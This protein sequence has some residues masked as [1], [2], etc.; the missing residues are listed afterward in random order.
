MIRFDDVTMNF[1]QVPSPR[2][3]VS[4]EVEREFVFLVGKSGSVSPPSPAR[5]ARDE[6]NER[7]V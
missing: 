3:I 1:R 7:Q 4:L 5:Y 2:W 6:S